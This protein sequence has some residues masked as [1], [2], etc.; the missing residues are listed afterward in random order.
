MRKVS[1]TH[2]YLDEI[3]ESPDP[4]IL[5]VAV[6]KGQTRIQFILLVKNHF[7]QDKSKHLVTEIYALGANASLYRGYG[8]MWEPSPRRLERIDR[9][10]WTVYQWLSALAGLA[11]IPL[12]NSC[13]PHKGKQNGGWETKLTVAATGFNLPQVRWTS[14]LSGF[15]NQ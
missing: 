1:N 3:S 10:N 15:M 13:D 12:D 2:S 14:G 5:H 4:F 8:R 6:L 9:E 7:W 11:Y